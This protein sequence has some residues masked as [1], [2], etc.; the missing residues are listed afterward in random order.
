MEDVWAGD[1]NLGM[2]MKLTGLKDYHLGSKYRKSRLNPRM[3]QGWG[4]EEQR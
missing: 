3:L 4:E 2:L 1:V